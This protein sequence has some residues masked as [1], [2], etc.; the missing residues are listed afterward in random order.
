MDQ[1]GFAGV[2]DLPGRSPLHLP[3]RTDDCRGG[4]QGRYRET[5]A[6]NGAGVLEIALSFRANAFRV[7]Y[8]VQVGR[9][10]WVMHAFQKKATQGIRTPQREIDVMKNRLKK[11]KEMLL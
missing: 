2:R 5:N 10:L 7:V 9:D 1:G 6:R 4:R 11:L 3:F 8:A